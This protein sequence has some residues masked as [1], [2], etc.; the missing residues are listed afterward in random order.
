MKDTVKLTSA[1]RTATPTLQL[2]ALEKTIAIAEFSPDGFCNGQIKT[3]SLY[4]V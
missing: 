2:A 1:K 3:I 4:F